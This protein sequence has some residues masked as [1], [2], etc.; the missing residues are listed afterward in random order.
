MKYVFLTLLS[1]FF[2]TGTAFTC[3]YKNKGPYQSSVVEHKSDKS[4]ETRKIKVKVASKIFTATLQDNKTGKAFLE[5]LPLTI[6]MADLHGNEKYYDLPSNLPINSSK[7]GT[8]KNGDL[9][10]FGSRTV[11]LFYK[12]FS[13]PYSYTRIGRI[14]DTS[15]LEAV[16]GSGNVTVSYELD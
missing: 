3:A 8:I 6:K 13:T 16:L 9:M 7:P 12:R 2:L 14:D 5:L 4:M 10:L 11:V 15:G 1:L